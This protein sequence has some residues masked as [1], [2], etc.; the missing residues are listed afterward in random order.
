[1]GRLGQADKTQC[2]DAVRQKWGKKPPKTKPHNISGIGAQCG[3][4]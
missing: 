4:L 1:M 2:H 3:I